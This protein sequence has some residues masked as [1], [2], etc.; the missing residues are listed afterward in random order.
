[1]I[2]YKKNTRSNLSYSFNLKNKK[3][4]KIFKRMQL[5]K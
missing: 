1:M 4:L 3:G 5:K 2:N